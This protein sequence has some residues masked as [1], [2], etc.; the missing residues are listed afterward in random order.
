MVRG[1]TCGLSNAVQVNLGLSDFAISAY[2]TGVGL[3]ANSPGTS[4]ITVT[5]FNGLRGTVNLSTSIYPTTALSFSL[6][7]SSITLGPSGTSS[8]TCSAS[9]GSYLV[10]VTGT[11]GSLSHSTSYIA[12][13]VDDFTISTQPNTVYATAGNSGSTSINLL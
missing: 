13:G 10:T 9:S 8:L 5:S 7:P 2:P 12:F 4:N 1:T 3:G 11:I 6:P